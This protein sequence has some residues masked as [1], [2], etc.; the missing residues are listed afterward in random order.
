MQVSPLFM[1]CRDCIERTTN[2]MC[3]QENSFF[4]VSDFPILHRGKGKEHTQTGKS[5]NLEIK[6]K[7]QNIISVKI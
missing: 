4:S 2:S 6:T 3:R 7:N 1:I 5:N